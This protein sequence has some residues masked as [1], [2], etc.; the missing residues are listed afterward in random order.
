MIWKKVV[1]FEEFYVVSDTGLVKSVDR[2]CIV[3]DSIGRVYKK[4]LR[5]KL[6]SQRTHEFGYLLCTLSKNGKSSTVTVHK[7][8]AEAFLGKRP[9]GL[10]VRHLDG[11]PANNNL[12]NLSYGTQLENMRDALRHGTIQQGEHRY[13]A[14]LTAKKVLELRNRHASGES[15]TSLAKEIGVND[16]YMHGVL[17]GKRW[18][19]VEGPLKRPGKNSKLGASQRKQVLDRRAATGDSI[20]KLANRFGVSRTQIHNILRGV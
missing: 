15:A 12:A 11:N 9:K 3:T 19:S 14:K 20:T 4:N 10:F 13:N 7:M 6:I 17:I 18:G 8:V 1:G 5:G 2:E 16:G